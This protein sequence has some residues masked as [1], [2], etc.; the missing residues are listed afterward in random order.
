MNL[1]LT[2]DISTSVAL[3]ECDKNNRMKKMTY[4]R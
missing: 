3:T 2:N 1:I 4:R